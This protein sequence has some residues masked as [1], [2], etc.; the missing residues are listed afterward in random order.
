[1]VLMGD[2]SIFHTRAGGYKMQI[3]DGTWNFSNGCSVNFANRILSGAPCKS[4][5]PQ[6]WLT[7]EML[8]EARIHNHVAISDSICDCL[9]PNGAWPDSYSNTLSHIISDIRKA[10][11]LIITKKPDIGYYLEDEPTQSPELVENMSSSDSTQ[12]NHQGTSTTED[13]DESLAAVRF[14]SGITESN[15]L[16]REDYFRLYAATIISSQDDDMFVRKYDRTRHEMVT[17]REKKKRLADR[18]NM[19]E[20]SLANLRAGAPY[21]GFFEVRHSENIAPQLLEDDPAGMEYMVHAKKNISDF[22]LLSK[23]WLLF[24]LIV[25]TRLALEQSSALSD[26]EL[27]ELAQLEELIPQLNEAI[28]NNIDILHRLVRRSLVIV[29]EQRKVSKEDLQRMIHATVEQNSI[30]S[31]N[32]TAKS[33]NNG[34][35]NI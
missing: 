9:W 2:A 5:R 21:P 4:M 11:G 16:S 10:T 32:D 29:S 1:M 7:L 15:E 27:S 3:L 35:N 30:L 20:T 12:N 34:T 8:C 19:I 6:C 23:R 26:S 28:G 25:G 31:Q 18:L 33:S 22:E 14:I 17:L 13:E 24:H